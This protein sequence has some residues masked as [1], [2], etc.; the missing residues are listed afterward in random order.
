MNIRSFLDPILPRRLTV[1]SGSLCGHAE[2]FQLLN[3]F[4]RAPV[5]SWLLDRLGNTY[6]RPGYDDL[7]GGPGYTSGAPITIGGRT[8]R[9]DVDHYH[10]S[11]KT[12]N[13]RIQYF[14]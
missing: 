10:E 11:P 3:D 7:G 14:D 5:Q 9:L 8:W 12:I 13:Q 6:A 4:C 2:R 1:P